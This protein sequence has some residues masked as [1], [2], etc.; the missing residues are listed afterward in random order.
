VAPTGAGKA[1]TS[2]MCVIEYVEYGDD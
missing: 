1:V 2:A